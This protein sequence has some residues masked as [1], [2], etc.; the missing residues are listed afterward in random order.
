MEQPAVIDETPVVP[1]TPAPVIDKEEA[2][3]KLIR[4]MQ[5]R[6]K[7]EQPIAEQPTK[8]DEQPVVNEEPTIK[9]EPIVENN[10]IDEPT[11]KKKEGSFYIGKD[12]EKMKRQTLIAAGLE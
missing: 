9:E 3:A 10:V 1:E 7:I 11:A 2:K 6:A 8:I 5:E 4:E 12:W